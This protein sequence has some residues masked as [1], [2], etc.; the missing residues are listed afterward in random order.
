MASPVSGNN[1]TSVANILKQWYKDGGMTISTFQNRPYW[2]MI[3]KKADSSETEGST[4]QFAMRTGDV[5]S[6]NTVFS[7]AQSQAW[8]LTG[9]V[10]G[11][12]A[13][14]MTNTVAG[15]PNVGAINT[16]QFSV[17]RSF[18]YAYATISTV[19]ELQT[20]S[21]R[22]AFDP[23]V[24]EI[25]QSALD[26][27][28]ND[29][30]ISFFGGSYTAS[31]LSLGATG[32]IGQ[33]G[34]TTDVTSATGL[35]Y[36]SNAYDIF[37]FSPGQELDLYYNNSGT[38]T[39]RN[40]TS[41]GVGLF[42]G[43]LDPNKGYFQ[44][45]NSAGTPVSINSVFTNAATTD[46]ICVVND[47]NWGALTA[48][49]GFGKPA[50]I[51]S[52]IPFGGPVS[53]S[54]ANPF[55]GVNRNK[56]LNTVR[57]AGNWIDATGQLGINAGTVLNIEDTILA[58]ETAV[59]NNSNGKMVDTWAMNRIQLLKL[60][61]SNI[62]RVTLPGGVFQTRIP[63]LGFK[64]IQIET[65]NGVAAV[66]PDRWVGSNRIYGLH[67]PSWSYVHLGEPVEMY[68]QDG[69]DGL[70]EPILDAKGYRFFSFGNYVCDEPAA[71]VNCN[72]N[73]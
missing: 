4:F 13:N 50:G 9:N 28:G 24:T 36:L 63:G 38:L 29:Q 65:D 11:A 39:K 58:G 42:V 64:G 57:V 5:Q 51:E 43:A 12:G 7:A 59:A 16:T 19:L 8:G 44:V 48:T 37:K 49:Q 72:V 10:A 67:M 15:A 23:A 56:L 18:N 22:G 62:N 70:R 32:I 66:I 17:I 71:N 34:T 69:L 14:A 46:F 54:D 20:R 41:A 52:W 3:T 60:T 68:G 1:S 31:G 35:L 55:M 47:V 73:P 45:V 26:V 25:I 27:L 6:R 61:K 33:I 21:K 53:D 40:N 30:E 2:S